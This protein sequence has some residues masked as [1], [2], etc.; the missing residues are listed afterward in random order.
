MPKALGTRNALLFSLNHFISDSKPL[1]S[2]PW[3]SPLS[4]GCIDTIACPL[5]TTVPTGPDHTIPQAL[6]PLC[7]QDTL[8]TGD[9]LA[10][11]GALGPFPSVLCARP[12]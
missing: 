4:T 2:H 8:G 5:T 12:P 11:L 7:L 1:P 3:K 10:R 9:S 6:G